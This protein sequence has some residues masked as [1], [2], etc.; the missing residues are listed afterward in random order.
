[1]RHTNTFAGSKLDRASEKRADT[2]WLQERL[3]DP[4][5]R[6]LPLWRLK[7]LVAAG[8]P[9][10]VA[11]QPPAAVREWLAAGAVPVFLG[12]SD[13]V[14]YFAL[15]V[16]PLGD[17]E[18]NRAFTADSRFEDL[19]RIAGALP[20]EDAAI[21]AQAKAVVDW[22]ATHGFCAACGAA[23][24][25]RD[26][27]YMRRCLNES[28]RAQHFPRTDPVVIML[29]YRGDQCL[30]G[31]QPHFPEGMYSALAGFIEPGETIEEA[32]RREVREEAG[33][34]VSRVVY[35]STQ[36]WPFPRS[37][38]IGCFAEA[39]T[40]EITIDGNELADARW[41]RRD[42]LRRVLGGAG[43]GSLKV[44]PPIA[45]AHQ[46]MRAWAEREDR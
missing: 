14:A 36:P 46:L 31:R 1:M 13:D 37:L 45:I 38:M 6:V 12:I 9:T 33:I 35:H 18:A 42:E 24:E 30:V 40:E 7:P 23:T 21:L 19:R 26:A 4:G 41:V 16:S 34:E 15:D 27:G 32:V 3:S 5:T 10:R 28:C 20:G 2:D 43:G 17:S 44:P 39:L 25:V 8:D 29:A 11:W 22:H